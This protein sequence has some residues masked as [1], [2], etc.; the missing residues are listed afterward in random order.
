MKEW[1]TLGTVIL[2]CLWLLCVGVSFYFCLRSLGISGERRRLSF[3]FAIASIFF[4][5]FVGVPVCLNV[6]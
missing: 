5:P 1:A 6:R 3:G 2:I 4:P